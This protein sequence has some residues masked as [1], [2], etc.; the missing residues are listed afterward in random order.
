MQKAP[1]ICE[2]RRAIGMRNRW[3]SGRRRN[4]LERRERRGKISGGWNPARVQS[5]ETG[6]HVAGAKSEGVHA[7][8]FKSHVSMLLGAPA[9][10][11]KIALVAVDRSA[12]LGAVVAPCS[13]RGLST[14]RKYDATI[15]VAPT[16]RKWRRENPLASP[17]G[18]PLALLQSG[19]SMVLFGSFGFLMSASIE[20][21]LQRVQQHPLQVLGLLTKYAAAEVH[22]R[23]LSLRG[24]RPARKSREK[25]LI[26]D[27]AGIGRRRQHLRDRR[28][29]GRTM[30]AI[31]DDLLIVHQRQCLRDRCV[32]RAR[33][34]TAL[35]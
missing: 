30:H 15:P 6:S 29:R 1:A 24:R 5:D 10:K 35:P 31:D 17:S 34:G 12:T 26:G 32:V 4:D 19:H 23:G 16:C 33:R 8:S 11:M 22:H 3:Q 7:P 13:T 25:N 28:I 20:E 14:S 27:R 21:E 18:K 2:A 9:R